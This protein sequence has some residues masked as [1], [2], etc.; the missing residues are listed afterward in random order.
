MWEWRLGLETKKEKR[1]EGEVKEEDAKETKIWSQ[2]S[3]N[4]RKNAQASTIKTENI[5]ILISET[6]SLVAA[7]LKDC[8]RIVSWK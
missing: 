2:K 6:L 5:M 3:N 4:G 1:I 7:L 8:A